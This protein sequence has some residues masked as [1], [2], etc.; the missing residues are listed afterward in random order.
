MLKCFWIYSTLGFSTSVSVFFFIFYFKCM[1][2]SVLMKLFEENVDF[3]ATRNKTKPITKAL[4]INVRII[5]SKSSKVQ[6]LKKY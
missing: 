1:F 3:S 5:T 2:P 6:L 4:I